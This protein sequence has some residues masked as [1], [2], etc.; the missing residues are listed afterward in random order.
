MKEHSSDIVDYYPITKR[1]IG[2]SV[3]EY[4][5]YF[6]TIFNVEETETKAFEDIMKLLGYTIE[7]FPEK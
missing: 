4:E 7:T 5:F 3:Y 1:Y 6:G 2:L